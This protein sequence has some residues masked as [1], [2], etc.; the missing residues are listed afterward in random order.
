ME[1][2]LVGSL[3][4]SFSYDEADQKLIDYFTN[5]EEKAPAIMLEF[6]TIKEPPIFLKEG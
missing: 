4:I 1:A 2:E 5:K 6:N 3:T